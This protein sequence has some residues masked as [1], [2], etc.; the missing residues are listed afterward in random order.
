MELLMARKPMNAMTAKNAVV[1]KGGDGGAAVAEE[2]LR[3]STFEHARDNLRQ[4]LTGEDI[5][6]GLRKRDRRAARAAFEDACRETDDP[7][8]AAHNDRDRKDGAFYLEQ[9]RGGVPRF[10][11]LDRPRRRY[12]ESQMVGTGPVRVGVD[13]AFDAM[14][15]RARRLEGEGISAGR[16]GAVQTGLLAELLDAR[17]P[18]GVRLR[19]VLHQETRQALTVREA[20][21]EREAGR[22]LGGGE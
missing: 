21:L 11:L 10:G 17:L 22:W 7:F 18:R 5:G 12:H 2:M 9:G 13:S 19:D 14:A 6:R 15:E 20:A 16:I 8:D 4:V 3:R 1:T